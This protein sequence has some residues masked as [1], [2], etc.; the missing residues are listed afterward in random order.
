[1]SQ[2]RSWGR[3]TELLVVKVGGLALP[4][5]SFDTALETELVVQVALSN[6]AAFV[7]GDSLLRCRL[8]LVDRYV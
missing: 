8:V 1:V 7:I 5:V 6:L 3:L 4:T 2:G